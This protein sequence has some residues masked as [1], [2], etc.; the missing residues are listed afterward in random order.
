M[1]PTDNSVYVGDEVNQGTKQTEYRVQKFS[2]TGSPLATDVVAVENVA[3]EGGAAD[4]LEGDR[5]RPIA[6]SRI[7]ARRVRNGSKKKAPEG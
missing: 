5:R 2:S 1:D 6:R 3:G 7:R 4:G